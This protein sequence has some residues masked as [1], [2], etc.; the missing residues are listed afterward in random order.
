MESRE[1]KPVRNEA[2][3]SS[4][5]ARQG[6]RRKRLATVQPR[7]VLRLVSHN[8]RRRDFLAV[9][10]GVDGVIDFL[11]MDGYF[12]GSDNAEPYFVAAYFDHRHRDDVVNDDFLV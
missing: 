12:L 5:S 6:A 2:Q 8:Q 3:K 4:G 10:L 1:G 9:V 7:S 11:T